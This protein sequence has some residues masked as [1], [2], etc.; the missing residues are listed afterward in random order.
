MPSHIISPIDGQIAFSYDEL[1]LDAA[2]A[3]VAQAAAAQRAWAKTPLAARKKL[4]LDAWAAYGTHLD[5]SATAI[6]KMMGKP[7]GQAKGEYARSMKERVESLVAQA[8]GA[9]ADTPAP[10]KAGFRRWI[11]REP[12]G[13]VL[14][15][16]AWN[17]PLLVPTNALFASV[18]QQTRN[19]DVA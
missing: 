12:V 14:V 1:S 4:C 3:A 19:E 8:E 2:R 15:I 17:Y 16:A 10:E 6:T 18:H 11:A 5:E 7:V 13:V 9:L